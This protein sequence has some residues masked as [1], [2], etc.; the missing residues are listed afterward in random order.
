MQEELIRYLEGANHLSA[1]DKTS[2]VN[3]LDHLKAHRPGECRIT[4]KAD[5]SR[6]PLTGIYNGPHIAAYGLDVAFD[7]KKRRLQIDTGAGGLLLTAA[8]AKRLG[9]TPEYQLHTSGVGDQADPESY[10]SHVANIQIGDI[11][12]SDCMVEVVKSSRLDVDG[13]IG[14]NVFAKWLVTLD[15]QQTE[16]RLAPLP[17]RP[18]PPSSS[19]SPNAPTSTEADDDDPVAKDRYIAPEMEDWLKIARVGHNILLPANIN[20]KSPQPHYM[21]MDTGA[22]MTTLSPEF[23]KEAGKLSTSEIEFHGLSGKVNRAYDTHELTLY[24]GRFRLPPA[25]FPAFDMTKISHDTGFEVSGLV[26]LPTLSLLSITIDYRDNL[27]KLSYDPKKSVE[28]FR[29]Q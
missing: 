10:L 28:R 3:D 24:F 4:S 26:G 20:L 25:V 5:T 18:Q 7:G 29:Y 1:N 9:V 13:L 12:L 19:G 2:F 11:Q 8:A 17:Q 14:M 27:L 21:I 23:A 15:Y 6:I 16:L 22:S